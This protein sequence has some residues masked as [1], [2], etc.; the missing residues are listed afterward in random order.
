M[1]Y[2]PDLDSRIRDEAI[3][4]RITWLI[5]V[6]YYETNQNML[7]QVLIHLIQVLKYLVALKV[8]VDQLDI[9][10]LLKAPTGLDD[11]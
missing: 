2:Y 4:F 5:K 8:E 11:F 10:K 6:Y 7:P 1:S 3:V 9:N